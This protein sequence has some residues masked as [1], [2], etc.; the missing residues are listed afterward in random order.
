MGA[1]DEWV[2]EAENSLV[3]LACLSTPDP[4]RRVAAALAGPKMHKTAQQNFMR[5]FVIPFIQN[6]A[7]YDPYRV[8]KRNKATVELC[9]KLLPLIE[10]ARL[11]L[12]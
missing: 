9:K 3:L 5:N 11:P 4:L 2:Y 10:D 8:D 7:N 12:V 1:T 6:M